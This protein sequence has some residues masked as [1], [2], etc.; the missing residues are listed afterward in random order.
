MSEGRNRNG[1]K[2]YREDREEEVANDRKEIVD[3]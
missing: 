3:S 2:C 1:R